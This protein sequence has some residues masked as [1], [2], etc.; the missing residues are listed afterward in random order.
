MQFHQ[1]GYVLGGPLLDGALD[2]LEAEHR[3]ALRQTLQ[4][5]FVDDGRATGGMEHEYG[6]GR[7]A[8]LAGRQGPHKA[9]DLACFE[10]AADYLAE[11]FDGRRELDL[12]GRN[13]A[14]SALRQTFGQLLGRRIVDLGQ[15]VEDAA[16][17]LAGDDGPRRERH[18]LGRI[19]RRHIG[20]E[21]LGNGFLV[22]GG[23]GLGQFACLRRDRRFLSDGGGCAIGSRLR[24]GHLSRN[25][26]GRT[27][28][29][30]RLDIGLRQHA[31]GRRG[32]LELVGLLVVVQLVHGVRVLQGIDDQSLDV[33]QVRVAHG[34]QL[35]RRQVEVELDAILDP[36]GHQ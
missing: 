25:R 18:P 12:L 11:G 36:H 23:R 21:R 31:A 22:H 19:T 17:R 10:P 2:T 14:V 33:Q 29:Q 24:G 15:C 9:V 28:G 6:N 16:R 13:F 34:L 7:G 27:R 20:I 35:N 8:F 3:R 26:L 1:L 5:W 32:L 30:G 4:Q